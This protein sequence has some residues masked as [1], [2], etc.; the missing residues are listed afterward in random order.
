LARAIGSVTGA[1]YDVDHLARRIRRL[2][3]PS[4]RI[5]TGRRGLKR[6]R[7]TW[8]PSVSARISVAARTALDAA[9][10]EDNRAEVRALI[11]RN[12]GLLRA[13]SSAAISPL[14]LAMYA[15]AEKVA[16]LLAERADPNL[17]EAA[18]LGDANRIER[19]LASAPATVRTF[20]PD[21]WTAL[22]LAAHFGRTEAARRLLAKGAR[23]D[24]VARNA[25]ANQPLQAAIA[26]RAPQVVRL[27]L[28][29]G[30]DATHRSHGGFTAA[31]LA[32]E[33]D[34]VPTLELLRRHG[35]DLNAR[36]EGGKTPLDLARARRC[37]EA[38][39]WLE[40]AVAAR[41]AA[42]RRRERER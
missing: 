10:R 31:H 25:I 32:A 6:G 21:G 22:H 39:R 42:R 40:S 14:M 24:A 29:A 23:V 20:S 7:S 26:G 34:D 3:G 15:R 12:P 5:P 27:L 28:D 18:A 2:A 1:T 33:N 35:A 37:T 17:F 4:D 11:D 30:A 16:R 41:P 36:S 19:L 9:I 13:E 8:A 38:A